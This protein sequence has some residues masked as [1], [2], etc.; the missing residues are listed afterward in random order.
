M[1]VGNE[2]I[3]VPSKHTPEMVR[4]EMDSMLGCAPLRLCVGHVVLLAEAKSPY[5]YGGRITEL[6]LGLARKIVKAPR[7]DDAKFHAALQGE[8][9]AAFRP[10]ELFDAGD[11]PKKDGDELHR[12]PPFSPEWLA[13]LVRAACQAVPSLTLD[14]VLW[15]V[16]MAMVMH[17]Y[18]AEARAN[19]AKTMRPPDY[20][21][22]MRRFYAAQKEN[23][24]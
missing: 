10:V 20:A 18:V 9:D 22:A 14:D 15:R 1:L 11:Q 6:D 8:L 16:P 13:D 21:E 2:K 24:Q 17:L 23:R 19:G 7:M 3:E 12:I 4:H 5:I